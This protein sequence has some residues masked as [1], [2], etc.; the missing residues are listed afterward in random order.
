[1]YTTGKGRKLIPSVLAF[2]T[3]LN[4]RYATLKCRNKKFIYEASDKSI[5]V[6]EDILYCTGN[7]Q[8]DV[9][10]ISS[11]VK[12]IYFPI[13]KDAKTPTRLEII[14]AVREPSSKYTK[15]TV[16]KMSKLF[17][18]TRQS[19][20]KDLIF[21]Q[22]NIWPEANNYFL[23]QKLS[24]VYYASRIASMEYLN[25]MPQWNTINGKN[26][27]EIETKVKCMANDM[28]KD[29]LVY[30]GV[31]G[32]LNAK[33]FE[34]IDKDVPLYMNKIPIPAYFWKIVMICD[35][36]DDNENSCNNIN[37]G[38][39]NGLRGV[40]IV[41]SNN[42]MVR[43]K[44]FFEKTLCKTHHPIAG[45]TSEENEGLSY[46]CP[47]TEF[48]KETGIEIHNIKE[49]SFQEGIPGEIKGL[50]DI[51]SKCETESAYVPS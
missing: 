4:L 21:K 38:N 32:H 20:N 10:D 2:S 51:T 49:G 16:A 42:R 31:Y 11:N 30:T 14:E 7:H 9:H 27:G 29:L 41:T 6:K 47:V 17:H 25:I 33:D 1:M 50:L 37:T 15:Y 18:K 39:A 48:L 40:A 36:E 43:E 22:T 46:Y 45:T 24:F 23:R 8:V 26:W 34:G 13:Y 35:S 44:D 12:S 28:D 19:F 5:V 3:E